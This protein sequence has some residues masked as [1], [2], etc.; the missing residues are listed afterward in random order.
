MKRTIRKYKT[1]KLYDTIE[2]KYITRAK[3]LN[4]LQQG[5]QVEVISNGED[6]TGEV[7]ASLL[8]EMDIPVSILFNLFHEKRGLAT[9]LSN[10]VVADLDEISG[11]E[12]EDE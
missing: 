10:S 1:G 8:K 12:E 11:E 4:L 3:L 2:H 7:L 6:I 5:E 9:E